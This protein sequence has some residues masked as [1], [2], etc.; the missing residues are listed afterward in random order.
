MDIAFHWIIDRQDQQG[1]SSEPRMV[2]YVC[3]L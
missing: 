2:K 1:F 3:G